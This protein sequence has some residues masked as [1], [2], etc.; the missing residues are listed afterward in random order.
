[1]TD[2]PDASRAAVEQPFAQVAHSAGQKKRFPF[3]RIIAKKLAQSKG[4]RKP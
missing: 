2:A 4:E 1:M 3:G